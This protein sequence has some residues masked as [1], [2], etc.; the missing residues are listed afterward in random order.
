MDIGTG[1]M[2]VA[3]FHRKF[4]WPMNLSLAEM[5]P[6]NDDGIAHVGAALLRL[7]VQLKGK[8][9]FEQEGGDPRLYRI[10][11]KLEELGELAMAFAE[12]DE[13]AAADA[14]AD[15]QYLLLG[16]GVTFNIPVSEVFA[17]VHRSNMTKTR[18]PGDDR[19]KDRSRESGFQPPR[20][21]E[22][23]EK[24][25]RREPNGKGEED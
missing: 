12:K 7:S 10:Y 2:K 8:A 16:D 21:A 11:H 17:E 20:L 4:G 14:M 22:A 1:Q 19:M 25:R 24:G 18:G 15:L 5:D 23:I 6:D 9:M 13:V 3:G